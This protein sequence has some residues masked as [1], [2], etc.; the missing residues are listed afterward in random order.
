MPESSTIL[1]GCQY[2]FSLFYQIILDK[3]KATYYIADRDRETK[4][5]NKVEKMAIIRNVNGKPLGT[6]VFKRTDFNP[7][8]GHA[9]SYFDDLLATCGIPE[10][11]WPTIGMIEV[12][13]IGC[14]TY[15]S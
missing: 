14:A 11:D 5:L 13:I 3:H 8:S 6:Q 10:K 12:D 15:P 4:H 1:L 9:I 7:I 2:I